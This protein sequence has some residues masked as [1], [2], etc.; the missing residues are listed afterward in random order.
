MVIDTKLLQERCKKILNALSN[1][2]GIFSDVL[3][4]KAEGSN[5]L[6]NI[7]DGSYYVSVKLPLEKEESLHA[8]VNASLF[9]NL[10]TKITT[11]TVTL[12]TT[13][14]S[15]S[16]IG[17]G[18]YKLPNNSE[19]K[20]LTPITIDNVTSEF[21][22][23]NSILQSIV[24]YNCK[25][26]YSSDCRFPYVFIDDKGAV[27]Y[28]NNACFNT[29]TLEQPISI[30][31]SDRLVKLFRLFKSDDINFTMGFDAR[32]DGALQQKVSFSDDSLVLTAIL[33]VG[34][35][36]SSKFPV[37]SLRKV[38]DQVAPYSAS[39]DKNQWLDAIERLSLFRDKKNTFEQA[40]HM[41]FTVDGISMSD[42]SQQNF[43]T[44]NFVNP[45]DNLMDTEFK[46]KYNASDL[47]LILDACEDQYL[48]I[49]FGGKG[50]SISKENIKNILPECR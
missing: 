50:L 32:A 17:N 37:E 21:K 14:K 30:L 8:I 19:V 23:K 15:L 28:F 29:F 11:N 39:I 26:L 4:L 46:A 31:L 16:I 43:E 18:N 5:L 33:S 10:I 2:N 44:V 27:T 34:T 47:T 25:I 20:E 22:I 24:K 6:L 3:E 49:A 1:K 13:E 41:T 42:Y 9:L 35:D 45:C 36:V 12:K 40:I 48:T 7:T 38:A